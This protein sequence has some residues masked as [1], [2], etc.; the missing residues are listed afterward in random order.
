MTCCRIVQSRAIN[1]FWTRIYN[2]CDF[3]VVIRKCDQIVPH[4]HSTGVTIN[5]W[6][7]REQIKKE[8]KNSN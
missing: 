3:E 2:D 5:E 1:D 6:Y 8:E 4:L 7:I